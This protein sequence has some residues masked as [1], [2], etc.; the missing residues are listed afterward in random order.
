MEFLAPG[1]GLAQARLGLNQHLEDLVSLTLPLCCSTFLTNTGVTIFSMVRHSWGGGAWDA[2]HLSVCVRVGSG[3][4][5]GFCFLALFS[6][7]DHV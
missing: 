1:F 7:A 2:A 4:D 6:L 3:S 5:P